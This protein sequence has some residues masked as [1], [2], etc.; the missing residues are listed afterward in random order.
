MPGVAEGPL[1]RL[2]RATLPWRPLCLSQRGNRVTFPGRVPPWA[3]LSALVHRDGRDNSLVVSP[4]FRAR[5]LSI[6]IDGCGNRVEIGRDVTASGH[7]Q[8]TGNGVVVRIGDRS[9]LKGTRIVAWA[10]SVEIGSDCLFAN[11]VLVRTNDVHPIYCRTSGARLNPPSPVRVG[12]GVWVGME[13]ALSKGA[14]VASGSVVGM[15]ALV[16]HAFAEPNC[17]IGGTPA[18]ILRRNIRWRRPSLDR[19]GL[20]ADFDAAG[21]LALNPDIAAAGVEPDLHYVLY[22]RQEGRRDR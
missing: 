13:A 15:R 17:V 6:V 3:V 12:D 19:Y 8:V 9:E 16:T 5:R 1:P 18:R 11:G 20:P 10:A 21:Y 14:A 4:G 2:P 7:F 22:G